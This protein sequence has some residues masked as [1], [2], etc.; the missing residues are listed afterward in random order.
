M[1]S[2]FLVSSFTSSSLLALVALYTSFIPFG[3][4][5]TS[6]R[7]ASPPSQR[8]RKSPQVPQRR[9]KPLLTAQ[10][11]PPPR[12]ITPNGSLPTT[13]TALKPGKSRVPPG[14]SLAHKP[15]GLGPVSCELGEL[16]ALDPEFERKRSFLRGSG[17]ARYFSF[18]L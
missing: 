8:A 10:L 13:S 18:P 7:S 15:V 12:P 5:H 14:P 11:F 3:L 2:F 6:P 17:L 4:H 9:P 16:G 1:F